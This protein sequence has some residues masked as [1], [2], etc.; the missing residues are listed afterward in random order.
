MV[1]GLVRLLYLLH[2]VRVDYG[3]LEDSLSTLLRCH[4][5]YLV[6]RRVVLLFLFAKRAA[7]AGAQLQCAVVQSTPSSSLSRLG[8]CWVFSKLPLVLVHHTSS[9]CSIKDKN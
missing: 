8:H 9:L 4:S 2:H 3:P 7:L 1:L 5:L 6:S